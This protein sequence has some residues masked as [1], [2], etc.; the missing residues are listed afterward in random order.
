[1]ACQARSCAADESCPVWCWTHS[2]VAA[3]KGFV[4]AKQPQLW[5]LLTLVMLVLYW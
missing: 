3:H 5:L 1:V 2:K 4:E